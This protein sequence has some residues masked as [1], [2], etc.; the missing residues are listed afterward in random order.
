LHFFGF[1]PSIAEALQFAR[2][3]RNDLERAAALA[4]LA[5]LLPSQERAAGLA[6]A[7]QAARALKYVENRSEALARLAPHLAAMPREHLASLWTETLHLL[8]NRTRENLLADL[9]ALT[10]FLT[11]LAGPNAAAELREVAQAVIDVG[12]WWP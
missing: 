7:L 9:T 10:P 1:S 11:A 4:E 2:A 3:I 6:E 8:A 12:R 5:P